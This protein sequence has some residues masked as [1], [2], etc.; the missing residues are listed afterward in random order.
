MKANTTEVMNLESQ[1]P[2][3]DSCN[4]D[5]RQGSLPSCAPLAL[6]YTP[7][8]ESSYP[9]YK[10]NEALAKGTLFPG[11][12]LPFMNISNSPDSVTGPLAELMALNFVLTEL[13]LYLDTHKDDKEALDMFVRY[14]KLYEEC[15][16]KY[17]KQYG[18]ITRTDVTLEGYTWLNDPWPWEYTKRRGN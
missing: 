18:P 6:S 5:Y 12:D 7:M 11:L 2:T 1:K 4:C 9:Q 10:S 13:G 14:T 16:A 17:V 8:Q 3:P 15:K